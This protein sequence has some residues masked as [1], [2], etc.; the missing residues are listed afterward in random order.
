MG[1]FKDLYV[2]CQTLN[3][4]VSRRL[5][6][7]KTLEITSVP[8]V[9]AMMTTL[10]I[11]VCRGFFLS[12]KNKEHPV[13]KQFGCDVIVLARDQNYCWERFVYT[14]ELMHL[15]DKDDEPTDTALKFEKLL[16]DLEVPSATSEPSKQ[17]I[18]ERKGIWMALACLCPEK[19]RIE[20]EELLNNNY[21]DNYGIA[22]KLRIPEQYVPL[23]FQSRYNAIIKTLLD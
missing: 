17:L 10:D 12:A 20:F 4:K 11:T 8:K 18:S 16:A 7:K 21:I 19:N 6:E 14:K 22:L 23:L 13:V 1:Q 5:I 9:S 3:P 15:F 2:F